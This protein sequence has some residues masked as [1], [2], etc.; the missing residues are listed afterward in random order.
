MNNDKNYIVRPAL[1][2]STADHRRERRCRVDSG[3]DMRR[4]GGTVRT[5]NVRQ[6]GGAGRL[7][8]L[9]ITFYTKMILS[10]FTLTSSWRHPYLYCRGSCLKGVT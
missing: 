5:A 2:Q 10:A 7:G 3:G 6:G 1:A 8:D 4:G 9:F